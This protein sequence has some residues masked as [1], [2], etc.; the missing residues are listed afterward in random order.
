MA[1]TTEKSK[2]VTFGSVISVIWLVI[3]IVLWATYSWLP[4]NIFMWMWI[5]IGWSF[6]GGLIGAIFFSAKSK[7]NL[8]IA[9]IIWIAFLVILWVDWF[10]EYLPGVDLHWYWITI[11]WSISCRV[12]A[13]GVIILKLLKKTQW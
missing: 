5:A 8:L 9:S 4:G 11:V 3:L 10:V 7:R 6:A 13:I 12:L 2:K 1:E